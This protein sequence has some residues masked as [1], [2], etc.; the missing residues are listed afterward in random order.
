MHQDTKHYV[1]VSLLGS[2]LLCFSH[3]SLG[4]LMHDVYALLGVY[5]SDHSFHLRA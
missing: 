4:G 1:T 2:G 3:C 5:I